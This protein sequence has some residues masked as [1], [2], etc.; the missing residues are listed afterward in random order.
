LASGLCMVRVVDG[1]EVTGNARKFVRGPGG[2]FCKCYES[3]AFSGW[4]A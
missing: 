1:V 3:T 2:D 4:A